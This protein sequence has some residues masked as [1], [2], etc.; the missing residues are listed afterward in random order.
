MDIQEIYSAVL[1]MLYQ[2]LEYVFPSFIKMALWMSNIGEK[3]IAH[4]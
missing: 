3:T 1:C 4:N 2:F